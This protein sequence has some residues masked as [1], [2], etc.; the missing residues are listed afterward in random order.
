MESNPK[1]KMQEAVSTYIKFI[2][3]SNFKLWDVKRCYNNTNLKFENVVTLA[4]ILIPY[5]KPLTKA[6]MIK[7]KWQIISKINFSGELFLRD[8]EEINTYKGNLYLVPDNAIIYSKI[9]VRHGCIYYHEKGK[10]P[11]GVSSEYPTYT[12]DETKV[13]GKFLHKILRSDA[14]K[15]LLNTKT[16]GISKARVKQDEFLDI[17]IPLPSLTEQESIISAFNSKIL[18]ANSLQKQVTEIEVEIEK[19]FLEQLGIE[20]SNKKEYHKGLKIIEYKN[21]DRWDGKRDSQFKSEYNIERI[22]KYILDISTGTTPPTNIPEYFDGDINFYTPVELGNE[23]YLTNSERKVS[24]LAIKDKKARRFNKGTLLFVGIGSTV[25]K[26][27][28]VA[29]DYATS[30]QQIT[31]FTVDETVLNNEFIF[32]YFNYFKEI[33]TKEQTKATLPIVNQDKILNIP[34]P[35][36]PIEKQLEIVDTISKMRADIV[37]YKEKLSAIMK[38]AEELFEKQIFE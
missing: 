31:G 17:Q 2:P 29:N 30:N 33:T 27:G 25:G 14:F 16:S 19:Y 15:K 9:N 37:N 24:E 4:D 38:K 12:F 21:L 18:E 20:K 23:M 26:I 13:S 8:F 22:G 35:I 36:L 28:I 7:N 32:F 3:F 11:F 1:L 6:E 34:I 5:R 10:I